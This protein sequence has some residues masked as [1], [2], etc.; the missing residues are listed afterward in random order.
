MQ[1]NNKRILLLNRIKNTIHLSNTVIIYP[2]TI[3][4][5]FMRQRPQQLMQQFALHGHEVYYCNK[6][7]AKDQIFT[8]IQPNLTIVHDNKAFIR[9]TIPHLKK[10]GK[11]ILVWVSWSKL[12]LFVDQY[13]PD[14]VVYDYVDDF[15]DWSPYLDKMINRA[16]VIITTAS[17]LKKQIEQTFPDKPCYLIPNGC[18]IRHFQ[19]YEDHPPAKPIEYQKHKGPIISY[20]GAWAHWVDQDL[21]KKVARSFPEALISIIGVEFGA[22]VDKSI[23]NLI[24]VGYKPYEFLPVYLYHCDVCIIPFKINQITLATNPIKMYEALAA[25]KPVVATNLPEARNIPNVYIGKDHN[26]FIAHI[27]RILS[28]QVFFNK[29]MVNNWLSSHTWESRYQRIVN[30]LKYE[31]DGFK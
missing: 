29:R 22:A 13:A 15:P 1:R 9:Q 10:Q 30:I 27:D 16:D 18:D 19:K 7:Q 8:Q 23:P 26:T 20:V 11:K 3:D 12:H 4:W 24:Y 2:P 21:V 17:V 28:S 14:F 5:H 31:F 6:F 25:G